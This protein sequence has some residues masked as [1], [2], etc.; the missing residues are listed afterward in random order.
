MF[1]QYGRVVRLLLAAGLLALMLLPAGCG[2][3]VEENA[4]KS[5]LTIGL[6]RDFY[7]GP[8]DR[9]FLHGSTNVWES[10]VYLDDNM[11]PYPWLA[12]KFYSSED[13]MTWTFE[14]REGIRFHDGEV[15]DAEN[16]RDNLLR[17]SRHPGTAQPYK[18]LVEIRT[19]GPLAVEVELS[20]PLP[21]FP[22]MISYFPSAI[23]SSKVLDE[24]SNGLKEPIGTGPYIFDHYQDGT[25]T[26]KANAHYW[27]GPPHIDTVLFKHIPDENTRVAALMAGEVDVLADVGVI[28]P[29]QVPVLQADPEIKLLTVDVLTSIY[30]HYQTEK[31]PFDI[32]ELRRAVSLLL[33]RA[34]L[35]DNLLDGYGTPATGLISPLA[36]YWVNPAV[37][38]YYNPEE[39][40]ELVEAYLEE[41]V[42]VEILVNANWARRW[43]ILSIAQYLQTELGKVGF[44]V[45]LKSLEMGAY[46][47]AVKAGE[48]HITFSPWTGSDPDDFFSG[49]I[50]S[51][52]SFNI[53]RGLR[54]S[55][56]EA[57]RLIRE[58][59]AEMDRER[60][61]E[62]YFT[63]QELVEKQAPL[64]P[65]YHDMTVYACHSDVQDF[66]MDFNFRPNLH[67]V[68]FK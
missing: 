60:R 67:A 25:I 27:G 40:K 32:P 5:E 38:P 23:Y 57:D 39:A 62:L 12:E 16:V 35:V 4:G 36:A 61:R 18:N 43:P 9:T 2:S 28:L 34:V 54:F 20:V 49:W 29:E 63:L 19:A 50:F 58:A 21:A 30:L 10:L 3:E 45:V 33:D 41:A 6:G 64:V 59:A 68:R 52:G 66:T 44:T 46:N 51:E 8:E 17:L 37:A 22:E 14:L 24:Q 7:Y 1:N 42:P 26:L 48:Y 47:D 15:M 56:P 65:L 13:G 11:E 53:S 55:D 31:A